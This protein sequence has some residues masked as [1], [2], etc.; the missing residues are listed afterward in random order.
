MIRDLRRSDVE[1][2]FL[3]HRDTQ[4]KGAEVRPMLEL[5]VGISRTNISGSKLDI[6]WRTHKN[7]ALNS[8][9]SY[10]SSPSNDALLVGVEVAS[11]QDDCDW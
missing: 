11:I 4:K 1:R 3:A 2:V 8:R 7:K 9:T 6:F 10:S 5:H